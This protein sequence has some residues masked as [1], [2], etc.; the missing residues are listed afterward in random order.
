MPR[1]RPFTLIAAIIFGIMALL[2]IYR[3]F[4]HFQIIAGSHS[5]PEWVSIVAILVTGA[6]S[7]GLFRESRR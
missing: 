5:I 7:I 2:H 1:T 4:T 3:L 6:L